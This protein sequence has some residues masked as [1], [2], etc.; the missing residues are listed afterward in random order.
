MRGG[1]RFV[2]HRITP[3]ETLMALTRRYHVTLAQITAANPQITTGLGIGQIVF[4]PRPTAGKPA[5]PVL[6]KAPAKAPTKA[7]VASPAPAPATSA[8]PAPGPVPARY[9]VGKGETLFGIAR[10]FQLTPDELIKL[11]KLP[12]GGTVRVG[13]ELLLAAGETAAPAPVAALKPARPAQ[14]EAIPETTA[15]RTPIAPAPDKPAQIATVTPAPPAEKEERE[16]RTP[17]RASEV[18]ARVVETGLGATIDKSATDKYLAL[19]KTAP[20]GTIMQVKNS[21]NGLSVYVRVIG[22]LPDTGENNN[23]LVR[24]S[25]RAVQKLG[26][27]DARFR[28]ETNY[29]PQ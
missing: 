13:Q 5:A 17:N 15:A 9:T 18:L 16:E 19:H 23:I 2:K 7:P 29:I 8:A 6:A 24:L 10:R 25:P 22:K 14:L 21:M 11:N 20:I 27:A 28:V 1:Q 26:T 12:A 4:V 3:G